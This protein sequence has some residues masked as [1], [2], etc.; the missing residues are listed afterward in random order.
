MNEPDFSTTSPDNPLTRET[1]DE[2]KARTAK[3]LREGEA[4][5]R[6]NPLPSVLSEV[7]PG[8]CKQ[9]SPDGV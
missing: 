4:F 9:L 6:A 5:L 7:S 3:T 2:T 1:W 8:V